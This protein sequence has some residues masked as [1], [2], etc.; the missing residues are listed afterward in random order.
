MAMSCPI[1]SMML[2]IICLLSMVFTAAGYHRSHRGWQ[3]WASE[4]FSGRPGPL[5]QL[6]L[7]AMADAR[8][9][10]ARLHLELFEQAKEFLR[11]RRRLAGRH[12]RQGEI[13]GRELQVAPQPLGTLRHERAKAV[14]L[15][16]RGVGDHAL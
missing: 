7:P 2:F 4:D 5:K 11:M 13:E 14:G 9:G 15:Q 16:F 12:R 10:Q 3:G 8:L 6:P 1:T